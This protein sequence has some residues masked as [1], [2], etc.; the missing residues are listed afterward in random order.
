M[1]DAT[2]L[3]KTVVSGLSRNSVSQ[4]AYRARHS[5]SFGRPVAAWYRLI[6]VTRQFSATVKSVPAADVGFAGKLTL[7][8]QIAGDS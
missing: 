5:R 4:F 2:L 1:R 7:T 8:S 6:P 3:A